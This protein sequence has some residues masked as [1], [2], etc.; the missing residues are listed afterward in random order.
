M[1][2]CKHCGTEVEG[3]GLGGHVSHCKSKPNFQKAKRRA[4]M[5]EERRKQISESRKAY[6]DKNPDKVPYRMYHSSTMSYP[7]QFFRDA[8]IRNGVDG[9]VYNFQHKRFSYD[10]AFPELKIDVEIDGSTHKLPDIIES[11]RIRDEF[12][13]SQGWKVYRIEARLLYDK[14]DDVIKDLKEYLGLK[15]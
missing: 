9:W 14:P 12:S 3:R 15:H 4:P 13:I 10:F 5:S 2:I 11:D 1:G 6:L 7:E 8:L